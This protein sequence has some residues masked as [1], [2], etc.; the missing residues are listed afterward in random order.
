MNENS[1]SQEEIVRC[2][3]DYEH[4]IIENYTKTDKVESQICTVNTYIEDIDYTIS[5]SVASK[6]TVEELTKRIEKLER[7]IEKIMPVLPDEIK[8]YLE[9]S[10]E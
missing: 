8:L 7:F 1:M 3:Y 2:L 4:M 5:T 9:V 10:E 6:D